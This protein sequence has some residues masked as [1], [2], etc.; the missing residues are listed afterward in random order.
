MAVSPNP[1]ENA[2]L[3]RVQVESGSWRPRFSGQIDLGVAGGFELAAYRG[4]VYVVA[5]RA[6]ESL[7]VDAVDV[8]RSSIRKLVSFPGTEG[9]KLQSCAIIPLKGDAHLLVHY[10]VDL[11]HVFSVLNPRD[12]QIE[13]L[14]VSPHRDEVVEVLWDA[15]G[16]ACLVNL[17]SGRLRRLRPT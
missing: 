16:G 14:D 4:T 8:T 1:K 13:E 10:T 12:L 15:A 2:Q 9:V 3:V 5:Q 17:S 11:R 6:G 7:T